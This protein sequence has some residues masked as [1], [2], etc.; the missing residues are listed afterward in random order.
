MKINSTILPRVSVG[1]PAYNAETWIATAI[2][3]ILNQSLA[4]F[5]LIIS[6]NG[7]TDRTSEICEDYAR[8]DSR[9]RLFRSAENHGCV[10]NYNLVL[11]KARARYFKWA[12]SSDICH[13]DL[14]MR[15]VACLDQ[16][17]HVVLAHPR[18]LLFYDDPADGEP[19]E[20]D[21]GLDIDGP[22]DRF[23]R[24]CERVGFN[25][26]Q[27]G[28]M[29]T[30]AIRA[31]PQEKP[32]F[33]SDV[34][35][36]AALTLVGRFRQVPGRMFYRRMGGATAVQCR[37]G[38][39][40]RKFYDPARAGRMQF[41]VWRAQVEYLRAV[42]AAP[43]GARD[44]ARLFRYVLRSAISMRH[45]L[46]RDAADSSRHIGARIAAWPAER[47]RRVI[48]SS[49]GVARSRRRPWMSRSK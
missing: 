11:A 35:M 26:H 13:L 31:T 16:D 33:G 9:I 4:D 6:D 36:M 1:M 41:Q 12:S 43:I 15:C 7:S 20:D 27:N 2:E 24:F 46:F 47:L 22:C 28:V 18:T 39:E 3:S 10:W 37:Y 17:P 44:K 14:L 49:G 29:R 21:L 5:E 42:G 23:V 48:G 34:V 32:Y 25:N 30:E 40:M 8:S 38:V 45:K 19:Y